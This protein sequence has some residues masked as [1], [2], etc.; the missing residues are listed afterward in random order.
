MRGA[1]KLYGLV[2][3]LL[4]LPGCR[5]ARSPQQADHQRQTEWC[6]KA[7]YARGQLA[8]QQQGLNDSTVDWFGKRVVSSW[9]R[10][11]LEDSSFVPVPCRRVIP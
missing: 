3:A 4:L 8:A 10:G 5:S 6:R 11:T 9:E 1:I 2:V 7:I